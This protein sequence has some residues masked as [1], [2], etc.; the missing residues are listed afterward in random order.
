MSTSTSTTSGA[1]ARPERGKTKTTTEKWSPDAAEAAYKQAMTLGNTL[2]EREDAYENSWRE[3][4]HAVYD[5]IAETFHEEMLKPYRRKWSDA[6]EETEADNF[7]MPQELLRFMR[8]KGM[9]LPHMR[10]ANPFIGIVQHFI[11]K[12]RHAKKQLTLSEVKAIET[13]AEDIEKQRKDQAAMNS[14]VSRNAALILAAIDRNDV[15]ILDKPFSYLAEYAIWKRTNATLSAK[16]KPAVSAKT[17]A[18]RAAK[19]AAEAA[20]ENETPIETTAAILEQQDPFGDESFEF[21]DDVE[22]EGTEPHLVSADGEPVT[23]EPA[24]EEV[25]SAERPVWEGEPQTA[26]EVATAP[27]Q[28]KAE[29]LQQTRPE[30]VRESRHQPSTSEALPDWLTFIN[31]FDRPRAPVAAKLGKHVLQ[32]LRLDVANE[33]GILRYKIEDGELYFLGTRHSLEP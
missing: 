32:E 21:D 2:V 20:R 12:A 9:K 22:A 18:A 13:S 17:L 27:E 33:E 31:S 1:E 5:F 29:P 3:F 14:M 26:P 6:G 30:T 25:E 4:R 10:A 11:L 8:D 23:G 28:A 16:F 19:E 24:T 7:K 15:N